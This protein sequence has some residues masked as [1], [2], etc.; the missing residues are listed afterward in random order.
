MSAGPDSLRPQRR[1][2]IVAGAVLLVVVIADHCGWL[3][4][5]GPD[6]MAAYHGARVRV[7]RVIDGNTIEVSLADRMNDRPFTLVRLWGVDA[8]RPAGPERRADPLARAARE[9]SV[10]LAAGRTVVL[11]LETHRTRGPMGHVLAHVRLAGGT[12][13]NECLL[14][15]GLARTHDRWPHARLARYAEIERAARRHGV[16]IWKR[17]DEGGTVEA[18]GEAGGLSRGWTRAPR[19]NSLREQG[20]QYS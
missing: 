8:P 12:T 1:P 15:E 14:A 2:W 20:A 7:R 6:D 5:R 18:D 4:V 11:S 17:R 16:G 3:L 13:L 9:R 10:S 19:Q